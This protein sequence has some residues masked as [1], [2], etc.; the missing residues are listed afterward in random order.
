[1][2]RLL[3]SIQAINPFQIN[4]NLRSITK[5]HGVAILALLQQ[6]PL[7]PQI[8][9][10]NQKPIFQYRKPGKPLTLNNNLA[11][12]PLQLSSIPEPHPFLPLVFDYDGLV[13]PFDEA[14]G[15]CGAV[16]GWGDLHLA[17]L[18][19]QAADVRVFAGWV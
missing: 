19:A 9:N 16:E 15:V 8:I 7:Y 6:R 14:V 11:I 12:P 3:A 17:G 13:I 10:I 1:M 5:T 2:S 4:I 18:L